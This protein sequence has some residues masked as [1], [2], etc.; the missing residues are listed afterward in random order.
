MVEHYFKP[1]RKLSQN[2]LIDEKIIQKMI[3]LAEVT[4]KDTILEIGAGTGFVT[5]EL[6][7]KAKKVIAVEFDE[8]MIPVLE[9]LP[10]EKLQISHEN[11]LTMKLPSF[12][13]IVS[14]PPYGNSAE[15]MEKILF[16]DF[17]VAVVLFQKEFIEKLLAF[18]GFKEF[19]DLSVLTQ[20]FCETKNIFTISP[21]SF[22]PKPNAFSSILV[23]KKTKKFGT[24]KN[25][26]LFYYFLKTIF[27][28]KNKNLENSLMNSI[29]FLSKETK[30]DKKSFTEKVN[31]LKQK[32]TK[33]CQIEVEDFVKIFNELF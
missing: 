18:P 5:R 31:S 26:K 6:L 13:K 17:E 7:K 9:T 30:I 12:N 33:V 3:E 16:S 19:N 11:F 8:A 32:G 28:Y 10:Q 29:P 24:A 20:Y 1:D 2:F 23:M 4:E 15:I 27:R 21:N 14:S 22:F 25:E